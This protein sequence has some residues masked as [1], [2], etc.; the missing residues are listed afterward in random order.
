[1]KFRLACEPNLY[2]HTFRGIRKLLL[3]LE[4]VG[5]LHGF[6]YYD[7]KACIRLLKV[8]SKFR[9]SFSGS[10]KFVFTS[11]CE[12]TRQTQVSYERSEA[13]II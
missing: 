10:S 1:M 13:T 7:T 4:M 6:R 11:K 12:G 2:L 9:E 8:W 3:H 5:Y